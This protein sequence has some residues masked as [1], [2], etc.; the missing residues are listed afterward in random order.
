MKL[1]KFEIWCWNIFRYFPIFQQFAF[2][3]VPHFTGKVP[4]EGSEAMVH[5]AF[6]PSPSRPNRKRNKAG[7]LGYGYA[8]LQAEPWWP[9][10]GFHISLGSNVIMCHLCYTIAVTLLGCFPKDWR[11]EANRWSPEAGGTPRFQMF[12]GYPWLFEMGKLDRQDL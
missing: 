12:P 10:A 2:D 7:Q 5:S 6:E 9:T 1:V 8:R 4:P 11:R 3:F